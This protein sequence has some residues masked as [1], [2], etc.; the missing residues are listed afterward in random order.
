MKKFENVKVLL[1][2]VLESLNKL[3]KSRKFLQGKPHLND[4]VYLNL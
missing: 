4:V 2:D 1:L 3:I